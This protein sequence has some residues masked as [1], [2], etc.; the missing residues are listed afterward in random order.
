VIAVEPLHGGSPAA[1]TGDERDPTMA[2]RQQVVGCGL[3]AGPVC[4][5]DGRDALAERHAWV[6]DDERVA[7]RLQ[8]SEFH[9]RLFR[10][11]DDRPVGRT[12]GQMLEDGDLAV[13]L[14]ERRVEDKAPVLL[15]DRLERAGEDRREVVGADERHGPCGRPTALSHSD[16]L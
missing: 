8:R 12:V 4:G 10:Q 5:R 7:G 16:S 14:V 9:G 1:P 13:V 11:H 2:E 6:C 3:G 15:V